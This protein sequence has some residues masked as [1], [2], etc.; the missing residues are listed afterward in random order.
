MKSTSCIYCKPQNFVPSGTLKDKEE[1][2][3]SLLDNASVD[4]QVSDLR[5]RCKARLKD[6]GLSK[7]EKAALDSD[8]RMSYKHG[9]HG[10]KSMSLKK[11][12][13]AKRMA[14]IYNGLRR[15]IENNPQNYKLCTSCQRK[16]KLDCAPKQ[17]LDISKSQTVF[18][19]AEID[20]LNSN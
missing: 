16:L 19:E 11:S 17:T 7:R 9:D 20:Y 1:E 8:L 18:D 15:A 12:K 5:S 4:E 3:S 2:D 14:S 6:S 13:G 10:F